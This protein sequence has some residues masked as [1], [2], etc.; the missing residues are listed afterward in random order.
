MQGERQVELYV[1]DLVPEGAGRQQES[2][3]ERLEALTETERLVEFEVLVWGHR[4]PV[5]GAMTRTT[6]GDWVLE[7]VERF[8]AWADREGVNLPGLFEPRRSGTLFEECREAITLPAVLLVEYDP[9]GEEL[10]R[11]T[12]H[13]D[14]G[15]CHTVEERL[16]ELEAPEVPVVEATGGV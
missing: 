3:V 16:R 6:V 7:R 9:D 1:R 8:R 5:A 10:V 14:D 12:P 15:R 11:V 13:L 4:A 2:I